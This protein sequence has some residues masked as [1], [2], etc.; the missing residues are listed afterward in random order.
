[1]YLFL[2]SQNLILKDLFT[3]CLTLFT[4]TETNVSLLVQ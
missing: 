3:L 2:K 1:M 4:K